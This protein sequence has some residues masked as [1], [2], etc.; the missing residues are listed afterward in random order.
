MTVTERAPIVLIAHGSQDPR[1]A[2]TMRCLA[3][4]VSARWPAPVTAAFLD[5]NVPSVRSALRGLPPGA[6]ATPVVVPA[7]LTR[8]YHGRVDIPDALASSGVEARLARVLGP[9]QQGKAPDPRLLAALRRR[10]S[11]LDLSYD[12]L[13]L[14]AAGTADAAARSTVDG[15]AAALSTQLRVPCVA[16]YASSSSPTAAEAVAAV[17]ALGAT[18]VAA[19]SYFL[20]PGRLHDTAAAAARSAGAHGVATPLGAAEELVYLVLARAVEVTD[21]KSPGGSRPT[22]AFLVPGPTASEREPADLRAA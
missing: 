9:D 11:E 15:V 20:A 10:L 6:A 4:G 18:R 5:F 21:A 3:A 17:H 7:L 2:S 19:S 13:V 22:G 1:S 12:G 14:L 8:A 16:G